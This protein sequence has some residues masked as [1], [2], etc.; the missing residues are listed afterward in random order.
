MLLPLRVRR[1]YVF[2]RGTLRDGEIATLSRGEVRRSVVLGAPW[3]E[4][5]DGDRIALHGLPY[6]ATSACTTMRGGWSLGRIADGERIVIA[7]ELVGAE[8]AGA[9][10]PDTRWMLIAHEASPLR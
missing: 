2:L 5:E 7:G 6:V 8:A 1:R 3:V 4:D 9:R 10:D